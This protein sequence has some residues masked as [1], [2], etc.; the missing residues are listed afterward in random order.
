M[1]NMKR[2]LSVILFLILAG[3]AFLGIF[4]YAK[5]QENLKKQRSDT[6]E[7]VV[8]YTDLQSGMLEPLNAPFYKETGMKLDIV[9]L[10]SNQMVQGSSDSDKI[11][12]VYITSQDSLVKLKDNKMLEPYFSSRTDT[13]LNVFRDD[14]SYWTG[15]WIDPVIFAVNKDFI[16]KHPAFSYTWTE[17]L[18]RKSVQLSMTDFIAADMAEDLLMCMAEHFGINETFQLLYQ[19]QGHVVQYGKYLSTPS[20]MAAMGKCDIGISG[21]NETLRTRNENMP[22][23]IIYPEDGSPW[24]L[25]GAGLSKSSLNPDRGRQFIEWL[26]NPEGYKKIMEQNQYYYVYV[27]DED[28]KPDVIGGDLR[29]WDLKKM[30]FDEGK[31]DLLNQWADK[32]RFG[33]TNN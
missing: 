8:V 14:D 1:K 33:G 32:I 28:M 15:I 9:Y 4:Q 23:T 31:K 16:L 10:T 12:D 2:L 20:R 21:L 6:T 18:T 25:Y 7:K 5:N 17:V 29:F 26:L 11:P 19:A 13:A 30:Y 22:V 3:A 24:Y 27:N